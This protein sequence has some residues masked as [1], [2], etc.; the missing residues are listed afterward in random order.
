M[1]CLGTKK[2][3]LGL[4]NKSCL[5]P[6]IRP[7]SMHAEGQMHDFL[8]PNT[9]DFV[10]AFTVPNH[11]LFFAFMVPKHDLFFVRESLYRSMMP[12]IQNGR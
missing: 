2:I 11:D 9:H 3:M 5:G 4:Q 7:A 12:S 6:T 10:P 1:S 8:G